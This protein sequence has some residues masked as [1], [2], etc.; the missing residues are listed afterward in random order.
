MADNRHVG[1]SLS[2]GFC[3]DNLRK[4]TSVS[5]IVMLLL[6]KHSLGRFL[7]QLT[8]P[9]W[10]GYLGIALNAKSFGR[11]TS[12]SFG[13]R[14]QTS[15]SLLWFLSAKD[16]VWVSCGLFGMDIY[17][18][19]KGTGPMVCRIQK[20]SFSKA[21]CLLC[22]CE[23][24]MQPTPDVKDPYLPSYLQ[25]RRCVTIPLALTSYIPVMLSLMQI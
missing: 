23:G 20:L 17:S 19:W 8:S 22:Q 2:Y 18:M 13:W 12:V 25:C 1:F 5:Y 16:S 9:G 7:P 14:H 21:V 3:G 4:A 6:L 10:K 24:D 15:V 11:L